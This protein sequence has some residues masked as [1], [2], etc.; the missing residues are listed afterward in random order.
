ML[1]C[2][3]PLALFFVQLAQVKENGRLARAPAAT[4]VRHTGQPR[5]LYDQPGLIEKLLRPLFVADGVADAPELRQ[6][7][8][9]VRAI[10]RCAPQRQRL[11]VIIDR[12]LPAAQRISDLRQLVE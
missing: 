10:A 3:L 4:L 9:F 8:G 1:E 12:L 2:L 5:S 7:R 6:R 11:V